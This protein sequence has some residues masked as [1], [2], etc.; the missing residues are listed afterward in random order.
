[1][2][3]PPVGVEFFLRGR[4]DGRT[5]GE[6]ER[7]TGLTKLMAGFRKFAI[8]STK[9]RCST[10]YRTTCVRVYLSYQMISAH[11]LVC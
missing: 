7:R 10:I 1:M 4:P 9:V 2:E 8:A 11:V 6:M 3:T 5:G